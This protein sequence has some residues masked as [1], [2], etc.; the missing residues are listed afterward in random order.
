LYHLILERDFASDTLGQRIPRN[1]TLSF[2]TMKSD[3]YGQL[4]IRFKNLD[5]SKNPVLQF[6]QGDAVT[7][8]FPLTAATFTQQLFIPGEYELRILNDANKN[9][10]WD[11]GEFFGKHKQPEIV[12]PISRKVNIKSNWENQFEI[13]L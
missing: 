9:G 4:S 5:L 3:E 10:I 6:V 11:P 13:A 7:N 12:K 2:L 1:D 8:S